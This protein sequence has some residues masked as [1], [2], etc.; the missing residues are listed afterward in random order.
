VA[1]GYFLAGHFV[2]GCF[3]VGHFIAV[4]FVEGRFVALISNHRIGHSVTM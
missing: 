1:S 3:V 4:D 2:A